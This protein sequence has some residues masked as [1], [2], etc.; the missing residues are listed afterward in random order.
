MILNRLHT[1]RV[2]ESRVIDQQ[3]KGGIV[4][5]TVRVLETYSTS[6]RNLQEK[7]RQLSM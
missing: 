4:N 7:T 6:I 1:K 5:L 2:N 3:N